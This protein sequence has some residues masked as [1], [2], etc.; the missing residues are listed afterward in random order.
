MIGK[1]I[2]LR[3]PEPADI[4][5]LYYWE[6]DVSLWHLGSTIEPLSKFAIEQFVMNTGQDIYAT[7]QIRLMIDLL[8]TE[9][10]VKTIGTIDLFDFDPLHR[11]AGV[12]ILIVESFRRKG[13]ATEALELLIAYCFGTLHLHQVFCNIE[14][15][16]QLSIRLFEKCGFVNCG[17][18]QEWL[19]QQG[20]WCNELMFQ[21]INSGK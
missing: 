16:N 5:L 3:A 9:E 7:R 10:S 1:R 20:H 13:Y 8:N 17:Q 6:N 18:K 11:R 12:G 15:S 4:N 21:R 14:S 19:L 2:R